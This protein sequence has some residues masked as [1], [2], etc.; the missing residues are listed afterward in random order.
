[1]SGLKHGD[2]VQVFDAERGEFILAQFNHYEDVDVTF[3]AY[4]GTEITDSPFKY[5]EIEVVKVV[6]VE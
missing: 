6:P 3:L 5:E 1:M 4:F 2:L